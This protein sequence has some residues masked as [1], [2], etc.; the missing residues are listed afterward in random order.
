MSQ[1]FDGLKGTNK[2]ARPAPEMTKRY[3]LLI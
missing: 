3:E 2:L 1:G